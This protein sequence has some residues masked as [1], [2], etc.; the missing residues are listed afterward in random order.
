MLNSHCTPCI[1]HTA[2]LVQYILHTLNNTHGTL[3][4]YTLH[5]LHNTHFT[6]CTTKSC[7]LAAWTWFLTKHSE[8]DISILPLKHQ[9]AKIL[10]TTYTYNMR[11]L[12]PDSTEHPY[13]FTTCCQ[14]LMD[15]QVYH[16]WVQIRKTQIT[17][18]SYVHPPVQILPLHTGENPDF[19]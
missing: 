19:I 17:W 18:P 9:D 15:W 14:S 13:P 16:V 10:F 7:W 12:E 3:V 11:Q 5:A 1:I 2:H 6:P 4:Q 8:L